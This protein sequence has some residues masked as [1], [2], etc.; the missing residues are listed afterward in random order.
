MKIYAVRI[1]DRYG[2]EYEEYLESKLDYE[3]VWIRDEYD[4]RIKLQWNKMLAMNTGSDEPVCVMDIDVLLVGDYTKLFEFPIEPGQ[5]AHAPNWW[6]GNDTSAHGWKVNGG[7]YKYYPKDC[8]YIYDKF[9][10]NPGYWQT[11]YI[12]EGVTTGPINGEQNFVEESAK[13]QL[14]MISMPD[15]WFARMDA[16]ESE[17]SSIGRM[18]RLYKEKTGNPFMFMGGEFH[19]DVKF[20]HFTNMDNRPKN[21]KYYDLFV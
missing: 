5:F 12:K 14:E 10:E 19:D 16:R 4:R 3:F 20:V 2:P 6:R 18:N 21:W 17:R 8:Q 15:A 7:L 13:E 11:K 1:G 9:M